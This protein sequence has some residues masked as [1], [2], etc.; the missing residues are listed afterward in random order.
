[1]QSLTVVYPTRAKNSGF[2]LIATSHGVGFR[3]VE[4]KNGEN[5]NNRVSRVVQDS[6]SVVGN[7]EGV[8][9]HVKIEEGDVNFGELKAQM[10]EELERFLDIWPKDLR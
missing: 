7:P 2:G 8:F 3:G 6:F 10:V 1:M 5:F 9:L 4:D